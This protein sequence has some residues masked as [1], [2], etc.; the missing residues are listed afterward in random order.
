MRAL[1]CLAFF[2]ALFAAPFVVIFAQ[3]KVDARSEFLDQM[4]ELNKKL[5]VG[6]VL[7]YAVAIK[8][9]GKGSGKGQSVMEITKV[10]ENGSIQMQAQIS[11]TFDDGTSNDETQI[12]HMP[13]ISLFREEY[14]YTLTT[15]DI[16]LAND[17]YTNCTVVTM[18]GTVETPAG[19]KTM[20]HKLWLDKT[21]SCIVKWEIKLGE[22]ESTVFELVKAPIK[23]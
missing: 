2:F 6:T 14:E 18:S 5:E 20:S 16:Q 10:E 19:K 13:D 12:V 17:S 11:L 21:V 15:E 3:E 1:A 23:H 7:E 8:S 9:T 4:L 22:T